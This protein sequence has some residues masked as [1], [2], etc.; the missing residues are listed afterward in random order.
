[1]LVKSMIHS[2]GRILCYR[3]LRR[4]INLTARQID[5][6]ELANSAIVF[7]PHPDDETLGCGGTIIKKKRAGAKIRVV[8]TTDG[9]YA[10][11]LIP[12]DKMKAIRESEAVAAARSLGLEE[13]DIAFLEFENRKLEKNQEAAVG[14]VTG[15]LLQEQP[16]QV[17]IPYYRDILPDHIFTNRIVLSAIQACGKKVVIYEYPVW[18]WYHWP[19]VSVSWCGQHQRHILVR[20]KC[21]LLAS[22]RFLRDFRCFVYIGDVLKLKRT[23]LEN[24]KSQMTR[25]IPDP[26]QP[27]LAEVSNGEFLQCFYQEREI[28][29]RHHFDGKRKRADSKSFDGGIDKKTV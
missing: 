3:L 19:W 23:A 2:P 29:Y 12:E 20:L 17:F 15:I 11:D 18:F 5:E 22:L 26:R 16:T 9:R 4:V 21:N 7:A 14:K 10:Q 28:F 1:M 25:P 13:G 8:F 6:D 24:Y 27:M